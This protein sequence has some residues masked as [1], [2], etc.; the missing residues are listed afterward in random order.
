M[1]KPILDLCFLIIGLVS[2]GRSFSKMGLPS[3]TGYIVLG[4]MIGAHGPDMF[5]IGCFYSPV[6]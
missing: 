5:H 4:I 2:F 6:L 3:V 1:L